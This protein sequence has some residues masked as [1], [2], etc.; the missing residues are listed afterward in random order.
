M[1]GHGIKR[2]S[3][4]GILIKD[5]GFLH[6]VLVTVQKYNSCSGILKTQGLEC[7]FLQNSPLLRRIFSNYRFWVTHRIQKYFQRF[8][9][10]LEHRVTATDCQ[11]WEAWKQ[12]LDSTK[13]VSRRH[14][15]SGS[16][17]I[18]QGFSLTSFLVKKKN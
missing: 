9:Y 16:L 11:S 10:H 17:Q 5:Y 8:Y 4:Q 15:M 18:P 14:K 7:D 1:R 12:C 3:W 6:L 2:C 13:L